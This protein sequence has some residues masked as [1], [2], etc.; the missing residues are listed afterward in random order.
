MFFQHTLALSFPRNSKLF[1][2]AILRSPQSTWPCPSAG[3][4]VNY[5]LELGETLKIQ[6]L[7]SYIYNP[8]RFKRAKGIR[9]YQRFAKFWTQVMGVWFKW[10]SFFKWLIFGSSREFSRVYPKGIS[11]PWAFFVNDRSDRSSFWLGLL[12]C[13]WTHNLSEALKLG[14]KETPTWNM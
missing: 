2:P 3:S 1:Q 11:G 12:S 9:D 6:L 8:T 10:F 5:T 4:F 13:W 14:E 7:V